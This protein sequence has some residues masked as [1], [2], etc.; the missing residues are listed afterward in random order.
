MKTLLGAGALLLTMAAGA[1]SSDAFPLGDEPDR[2]GHHQKHAGQDGERDKAGKG[3]K[4]SRGRETAPGQV[5]KAGQGPEHPHGSPPGQAQ[6]DRG[7]PPAWAG[8]PDRR[9]AE[10]PGL[11]KKPDDHPA[12][13]HGRP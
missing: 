8:G 1:W 13:T 4:A 10:P 12:K 2:D 11:A 3:D 5:K 9:T 7:E 6:R